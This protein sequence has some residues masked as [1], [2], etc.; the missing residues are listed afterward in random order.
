MLDDVS[1]QSFEGWLP[2]NYMRS[3]YAP[4]LVLT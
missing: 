3:M 2:P 4:S 1:N